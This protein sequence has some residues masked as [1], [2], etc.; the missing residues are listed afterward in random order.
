MWTYSAYKY[1]VFLKIS[2]KERQIICTN[3]NNAIAVTEWPSEWQ[4]LKKIKCEHIQ[5]TNIL[6]LIKI[7]LKNI[8]K[9]QGKYSVLIKFSMKAMFLRYKPKY[10]QCYSRDWLDEWVINWKQIKREHV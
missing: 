10:K 9:N 1:S 5:H 6:Y 2:V 8:V 4:T 3:I 7:S